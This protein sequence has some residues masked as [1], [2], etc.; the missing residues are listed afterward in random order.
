MWLVCM[1]LSAAV[2][3]LFAVLP[4][5]PLGIGKDGKRIG[6]FRFLLAGVFLA[7]FFLFFPV[8]FSDARTAAAGSWRTVLLCLF[9]SMQIFTIGTDFDLVTNAMGTCPETLEAYYKV[10]AAFIFVLAPVITFGFVLSF[11]DNIFGRLAYLWGWFR[12]TYVFSELNERS[13]ALAEDLHKTKPKAVFVFTGIRENGEEVAELQ[14]QAKK[15]GA[16]CFRKEL[17]ALKLQHH[18]KKAKI[19]L[20]AIGTDEKENLNLALTLIE[21][22]RDRENTRLY[23]FST[24]T[25]SELLLTSSHKGKLKVRRIHAVQSLI[26]RELYENGYRFFQEALP[27]ENGEKNIC[28]VLVGLGQHGTQMLKA[29]SWYGQMNSYRITIHAFDKDPLAEEKFAALAPELMS[30]AYNGVF[31][32][33]EAQYTIKI[34]P[35]VDVNTAAFA[36][37]VGNIP[38]IT[39]VLVALGNDD[40][41]I[42]TAVNMRMLMERARCHPRI[43]TIVY[44]ARQKNALKGICNY[45]GQPYDLD[46]IGDRY[47]AQVLL[48]SQLEQDALQR[49]L[50]W[51]KEAEFWDYEYNYRSSVASA[52]HMRARKWVG[53]AGADKKEEELTQQEKVTIQVLEHRRWNAYMRAEGYVYSGSK[54][55]S[56]RNDLGKMHHDLVDFASLSEEDKRKDSRVG[57]E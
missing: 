16:I 57:T 24:K 1:L 32:E 37:Q 19:S 11:F 56:S 12:E 49:H 9:N 36:K 40:S 30:E 41:N 8:H 44:S 29:L 4:L 43:Q 51:G 42:N 13:F 23:V 2:L 45:R 20:L 28:A 27:G 17:S 33:G 6:M 26:Y 35:G 7:G 47:T 48:G 46:V 3:V 25:E 31:V 39:Y 14:Q 22:F 53:I 15:L 54:D 50:K 18:S 55:K 52:I 38:G 5:T 21:Q 10:W 34:H